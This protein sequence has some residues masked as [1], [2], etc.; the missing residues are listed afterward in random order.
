MQL[1]LS[2]VQAADGLTLWP[3][4]PFDRQRLMDCHIFEQILEA[5]ALE[6]HPI[7]ADSFWDCQSL[8]FNERYL[9]CSVAAFA[10]FQACTRMLRGWSLLVSCIHTT[11]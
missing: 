11:S 10:P 5:N 1:F 4:W 8:H 3:E 2:W 7:Y 6:A 9:N